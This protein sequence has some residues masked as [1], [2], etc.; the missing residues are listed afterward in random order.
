MCENSLTF[1]KSPLLDRNGVFLRDQESSLFA[2]LRTAEYDQRAFSG[3]LDYHLDSMKKALMLPFSSF[4]DVFPKIVRELSRDQEKDVELVIQQE[5][6][7]IGRRILEEM[8]DPLIHLVR[9]CIDHGI[10][11]P[12]ERTRKGKPPRGV[13]SI[14]VSSK[15]G[16]KVEIT[17]TDDGTGIDVEKVRDAALK[18]DVISPE[19]DAKM[20]GQEEMLLIFESGVT[21]NST[22]TDISG[23]GLGLAIVRDKVESLGGA[24]SL[25][26]HRDIGTTFRMVLPLSMATFRGV[27]VR[28]QD[29]F[30][31]L[32]TISIERVL[33]AGKNEIETVENKKT[34]RVHGKTVPLVQLADILEINQ[35]DIPADAT[36]KVQVIVLSSADRYVAFVVDE[37]LHEQEVLVK[38]LGSQ[39]SRARNIAGAAVLG[40]GKVAPI[41]NVPDLMKSTMKA[42]LR[43]TATTLAPEI[44]QTEKKSILVA[45]DSIT[46]RVLLRSI[47]EAAGYQVK[48]AVD[49]MDALTLLRTDN[50]D[51]VVSDVD[52]PRMNGFELTARIRSD[53]KLAELPVVLVTALESRDDREHGI[54]VGASGYMAKSSFDQGDLLEVIRRLI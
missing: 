47:L 48:T 7:E 13:I 39:L 1:P 46:A 31:V 3:M 27:L 15:D 28:V 6:I 16:N 53:K 19:E 49:G 51:M 32:P 44:T 8:K 43:K 25:E 33:R 30:F 17:I 18:A 4:L 35:R 34:V 41:L 24:I 21:T 12:E 37:I 11:K 14:T 9:N 29:Y 36:D 38:G 22:I 5:E 26:S 45:E 42:A 23:R 10:E 54:E 52:M 50:F 2:L 20:N 40:T